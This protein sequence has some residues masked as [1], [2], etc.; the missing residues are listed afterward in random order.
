MKSFDSTRM[1]LN[2][3]KD[4]TEILKTL[5]G[6][7]SIYMLL[8]NTTNKCCI[9]SSL[10]LRNRIRTYYSVAI[11]KTED[12]LLHKA[13][14]KYGENYF[15]LIILEFCSVDIITLLEKEQVAL[16]I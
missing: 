6:K 4:K 8:C 13:I 14:N 7:A 11:R 3:G 1:W 16:N 12:R 15:S 10:E 5:K 2:W 9:D